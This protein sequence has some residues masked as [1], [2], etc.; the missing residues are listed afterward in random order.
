MEIKKDGLK[1]ENNHALGAREELMSSLPSLHQPLKALPPLK[2]SFF[3]HVLTT[4]P[5]RIE[6]SGQLS[7]TIHLGALWTQCLEQSWLDCLWLDRPWTSP[8]STRTSHHGDSFFPEA[9][10]L[11]T[12]KHVH[13]FQTSIEIKCINTITLSVQLIIHVLQATLDWPALFS[14]KQNAPRKALEAKYQTKCHLC[15]KNWLYLSSQFCYGF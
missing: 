7:P 13:R 4:N 11:L 12:G 1:T 15:S 2:F 8:L 6:W 5:G 10:C 14:V 9:I 3:Q